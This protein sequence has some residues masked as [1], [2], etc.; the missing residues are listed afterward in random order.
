MARQ[1]L[2]AILAVTGDGSRQKADKEAIESAIVLMQ[3]LPCLM[4]YAALTH[5]TRT[6]L[7]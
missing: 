3:E 4:R 5:P 2:L 7:I 1:T 6:F